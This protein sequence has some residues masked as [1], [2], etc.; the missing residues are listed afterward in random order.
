M[1]RL[2]F[3]VTLLF[4]ATPAFPGSSH[5][6]DGVHGDGRRHG[7]EVLKVF[8]ANGRVVGPLAIDGVGKGV[9]LTLGGARTFVSVY[10]PID[11][12]GRQHASQYAWSAGSLAFPTPDCSGPPAIVNAW[13]VL[14][15]SRLIRVGAKVTLYLAPDGPS[16]T[17]VVHSTSSLGPCYTYQGGHSGEPPFT[18]EAWGVEATYPLDYPEPLTIHY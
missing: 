13:P 6:G 3:L 10:R 17:M 16:T 1:C 4:F 8:D 5:D 15:P 18:A 11:E 7:H 14:R 12:S 2:L 9:I